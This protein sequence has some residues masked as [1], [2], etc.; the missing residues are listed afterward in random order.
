MYLVNV[1]II[2]FM[3]LLLYLLAF[4]DQKQFAFNRFYLLLSLVAGF[5]I[6]QLPFPNFFPAEVNR[7]LYTSLWNQP[8]GELGIQN[9]QEAF[10][11]DK[12]AF[13][14]SFILWLFYIAGVMVV[15]YKLIREVVWIQ[16]LKKSARRLDVSGR[17]VYA[18]RKEHAPFSYFNRI[19]ISDKD[20]WNQRQLEMILEH[21]RAH[22]LQKHWVDNVMV[23]LLGTLFWFHP[24]VWLYKKHIRINHEYQADEAAA[25]GRIH[26]YGTLL[27]LPF[28]WMYRYHISNS[29]NSSP[30]KNRINMLTKVTSTKRFLKLTALI[31]LFAGSVVMAAQQGNEERVR[32]GN[33]ITFRGNSFEWDPGVLKAKRPDWKQL[34]GIPAN[35]S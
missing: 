2:W 15:S 10:Y 31:P 26:E 16:K 24:L 5:V 12:Y 27:L 29:F 34:N 14:F 20:S 32:K 35:M 19:Y 7:E 22:I 25:S 1:T 18:T 4:K 30:I 28:S 23:S 9:E 3:F 17:Y 8:P 21:E 33:V 6:P 13:D 11:Q